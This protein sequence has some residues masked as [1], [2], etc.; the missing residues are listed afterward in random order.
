MA[1]RMGATTLAHPLEHC[2]MIGA[3]KAVA[4][5]ILRAIRG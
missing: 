4:E 1:K 5:L 3:P 2:P